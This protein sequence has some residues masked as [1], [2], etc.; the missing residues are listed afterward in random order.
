LNL[1]SQSCRDRIQRVG[2]NKSSKIRGA[3]NRLL[4]VGTVRL[5][6]P[7]E[8]I[9]RRWEYRRVLDELTVEQQTHSQNTFLV[10]RMLRRPEKHQMQNSKYF[11]GT[12]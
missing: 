9:I 7:E 6:R 4:Q 8:A 12:A 3:W 5:Q 1:L 11:S 2:N 10:A